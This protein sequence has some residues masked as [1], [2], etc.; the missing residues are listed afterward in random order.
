[1]KK[2]KMKTF[3][4]KREEHVNFEDLVLCEEKQFEKLAFYGVVLAELKIDLWKIFE[5]SLSQNLQNSCFCSIFHRTF[6][7][8]NCNNL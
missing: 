1:M 6:S 2:N 8:K 5:A 7:Y 3:A 4:K